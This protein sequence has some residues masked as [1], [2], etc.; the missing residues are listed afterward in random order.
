M[1][2]TVSRDSSERQ[3]AR[4]AP[5]VLPLSSSSAGASCCGVAAP[6]VVKEVA[7]CKAPT[8]KVMASRLRKAASDSCLARRIEDIGAR[9][10][11]PSTRTTATERLAALRARVQAK[12]PAAGVSAAEAG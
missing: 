1:V 12:L 9:L 10:A 8:P 7:P 11:T 4:H 6:P 3:W 5:N 2:V